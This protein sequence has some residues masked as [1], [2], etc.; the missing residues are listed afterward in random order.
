MVDFAPEGSFEALKA[1]SSWRPELKGTKRD[2]G[3]PGVGRNR[4][5]IPPSEGDAGNVSFSPGFL[6][7]H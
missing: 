7:H 3:A 5:E 6:R 1:G 2:R 4:V